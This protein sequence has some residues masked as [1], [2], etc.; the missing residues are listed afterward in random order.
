MHVQRAT[1][2]GALARIL[3]QRTF[4]DAPCVVCSRR[5]ACSINPQPARCVLVHELVVC[6]D[7]W[8]AVTVHGARSQ[9]QCS[10]QE[11]VLRPYSCVDYAWDEPALP[12][13]L[14]L[15]LPGNRKL[16][17]FYLDK[18]EHVSPLE[19]L[20]HKAAEALNVLQPS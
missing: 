6:H 20:R 2:P 14:S 19:M 17:L 9:H 4:G 1:R 5:N 16:G 18:V 3:L 10:E 8:G 12:H 15:A 7:G 13:R 11:D